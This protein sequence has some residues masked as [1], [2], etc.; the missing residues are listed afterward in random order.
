MIKVKKRVG[1]SSRGVK[2]G[3]VPKP[4]DQPPIQF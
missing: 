1:W 2:T 3:K 4:T